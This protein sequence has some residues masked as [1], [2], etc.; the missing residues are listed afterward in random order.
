VDARDL[1][2]IL[3]AGSIVQGKLSDL[4]LLRDQ[5]I[6]KDPRFHVVYWCN[7]NVRLYVVNEDDYLLL[8]KIKEG[9]EK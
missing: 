6:G 5:I 9:L 2:V 3:S 1:E 8:K 4:I 7:S